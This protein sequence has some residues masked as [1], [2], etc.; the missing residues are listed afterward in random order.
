MCPYP[1]FLNLATA[2]DDGD[3]FDKGLPMNA[4]YMSASPWGLLKFKTTLG[5]QSYNFTN[6]GW[7]S[8]AN[9]L[10]YCNAGPAFSVETWVKGNA[11]NSVDYVFST[12][13]SGGIMWY[14]T[15]ERISGTQTYNLKFT[16][17]NTLSVVL[18]STTHPAVIDTAWH[19]ICFAKLNSTSGALFVDGV[20]FGFDFGPGLV[21][22]TNMGAYAVYA[23][24]NG[25][26]GVAGFAGSISQLRLTLGLAYDAKGFTPPASIVP[27]PNDIF[28]L[29]SNFKDVSANPVGPSR[30]G[31]QDTVTLDR[32][33]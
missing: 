7:M 25:R 19:H 11:T 6:S 33:W 1:K 29:G 9:N 27:L 10:E 13:F 30:W 16:I 31:A 5:A 23:G 2:N 21:G 18:F 20:L 15:L 4:I 32:R 14:L 26:S 22:V 12:G 3:A 24:L 28:N 8:K 17:M